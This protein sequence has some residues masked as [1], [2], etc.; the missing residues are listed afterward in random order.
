MVPTHQKTTEAPRWH[1]FLVW[2]DIKWATKANIWPKMARV[3]ESTLSFGPR[4]TKLAPDFNL[5][6]IL[7]AIED[8]WVRARIDRETTEKNGLKFH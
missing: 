2:H 4:M 8:Y 1:C 3:V 5:P 6:K 7:M